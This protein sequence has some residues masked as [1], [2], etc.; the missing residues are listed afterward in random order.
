MLKRENEQRE[1]KT[2]NKHSGS[3]RRRREIQAQL[4]PLRLGQR[5]AENPALGNAGAPKILAY[6]GKCEM[7]QD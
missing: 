4:L 1:K 6:P 2:V 3:C 5:T 7:L